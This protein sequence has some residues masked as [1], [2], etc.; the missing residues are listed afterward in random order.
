MSIIE[1]VAELLGPIEQGPTE[2][3]STEQSNSKSPDRSELDPIERAVSESTVHSAVVE[4]S[5]L[6]ALPKLETHESASQAGPSPERKTRGTPAKFRTN[7]NPA[8]VK[9]SPGSPMLRID[10]DHLHQQGIIP[11]DGARTPVAECIRLIK[12]QLLRNVAKIKSD[13]PANVIMVTSSVPSEGKTF[14]AVNLA[15]SIAQDRNRRVLLVDADV[16][17][18]AVPPRLGIK[19]GRGLMDVLDRG[20][21][22]AEV[23]CKLDIGQLS[24]MPAGTAHRHATELLA[25]DTMRALVQEMAERYDDRIIIFD[26]PPLLAVSES[27]VLANHMGQIVVVVEAGKTPEAVLLNALGRIDSSKVAGL[28][29]NKGQG[30]RRGYGYGGYGGYGYGED[31]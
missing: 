9:T 14:T 1:R 7:E 6:V 24:F 10:R 8:A 22:V 23:L 28:V 19:V 21:D 17:K 4:P 16:A 31:A 11:P 26:S 13:S 20:I 29:L 5:E 30:T 12:S 15:I 27:S 3:G 18:P 2:K 25:S